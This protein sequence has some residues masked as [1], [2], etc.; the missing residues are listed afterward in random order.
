MSAYSGITSDMPGLSRLSAPAAQRPESQLEEVAGHFEALFTRMMLKSMRESSLNS[1]LFESNQNSQ[2]TEMFDDQ[3]AI[4]M[5]RGRG[6]GLKEMLIRQ[7]EGAG[8]PQATPAEQM[9]SS[10]RYDWNPVDQ[11]EFVSG[12]LPFAREVEKELG[13]SHKAVLAQAAL[14]SGWGRHA[15]RRS[16]GSNTFNLF[17]IKA[18]A[19]WT[20]DR[21]ATKTLE[22][23]D[24]VGRRTTESFRAYGSM[25]E[26]ARD[27]ADFIRNNPR[28][29]QAIENGSDPHAYARELQRAGYATDP[30]YAKK[31]GDI[32]E[33]RTLRVS[34]LSDTD[35]LPGH[36]EGVM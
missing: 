9:T 34:S 30:D 2:Y 21:V 22:F 14:E 11:Q 36:H 6:L 23:D 10:G 25:G 27:Y 4:Q 13:V 33:S 31:I 18:D 28:Y 19:S 26:A 15:I 32:L 5:S 12:L 17:G 3:V 35:G 20:G 29:S 1:G 24:G 8:S 16:D 7:L